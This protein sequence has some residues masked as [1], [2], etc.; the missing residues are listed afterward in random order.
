MSTIC[1]TDQDTVSVL[2]VDDHPLVSDGLRRLIERHGW[3][4][5]N[6]NLGS[7][8]AVLAEAAAT[9]PSV[10]L[11]DLELGP[12][13]DGL[14]LIA[15]L[16]ALG[17]AVVVISGGAEVRRLAESVE[18]G[19]TS[20]VGKTEPFGEIFEHVRAAACGESRM[21]PAQRE[22]LLAGLDAYRR[23]R[24]IA[25]APF[26]QLSATEC[27]VLSL[28]MEGRSAEEIAD[29]HCVSLNTVRAQIRSILKKLDVRSQLA[30][31]A[32][33]HDANWGQ[34]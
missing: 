19:A 8:E 33:A 31:V 9:T 28:V 2:V 13:G 15:P 18:A 17:C 16:V 7:A 26:R 1:A 20:F 22:R 34:R 24:K 4:A 5:T 23:A 3:R 30:A 25:L 29:E 32:L 21:S 6:P 10:V 27:G 14:D 11:L 12:A